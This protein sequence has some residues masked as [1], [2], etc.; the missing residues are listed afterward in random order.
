MSGIGVV[1]AHD[2]LAVVRAVAEVVDASGDLFVAGVD[3]EADTGATVCV[4]GGEALQRARPGPRA[5]VALVRD[6]DEI[7]AARAALAVGAREIVR[8]PAESFRLVGAIR[9]AADAA[10]AATVETRV[11]AVIGARGGVGTT[12]VTL[13]LAV[14]AGS[15]IA[16]DLAG[17]GLD[18]LLDDPIPSTPLSVVTPDVL[19][20]ALEPLVA[21]ARVLRAGR[22][23]SE[24]AEVVRAARGVTANVVLDGGRSA[25]TAAIADAVVVV[26]AD[27]VASARG[28]RALLASGVRPD[29]VI[30][31]RERRAG[32]AARDAAAAADGVPW[33]SVPRDPV[34]ARALD[35]GRWPARPTRAMRILDRA[36]RE[37]LDR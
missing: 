30:V 19:E 17:G 11:T 15:S 7:R 6:G 4:A 8:W 33:I 24:H 36:A 20:G 22:V 27:D 1:V 16:I 10:G 18:V 23:P 26:L 21:S 5:V 14:A 12:T 9:L 37:V 31:R 35:L 29:L 3:L 28:L 32:V 2:D 34:L 25:A 13:A